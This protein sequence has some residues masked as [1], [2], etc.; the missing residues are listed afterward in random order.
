[1]IKERNYNGWNAAVLSNGNLEVIAPLD[2]GPRLLSLRHGES[3]N[4]FYEFPEERGGKGETHF[5]LRGGHRLWHSPEHPERTYQPD[6]DP[7]EF[8]TVGGGN[9][10][11]LTGRTEERTGLRKSI[12]VTLLGDRS[13]RVSHRLTHVGLW[14]VECAVWPLTMLRRGGT[15]ALPFPRKGE[16]P[17]DLL[18]DYGVVPWAYTDLSAACWRFHRDF[19][20]IDTREATAPQKLGL[21]R[22]PGWS[23]YWIEGRTFVKCAPVWAGA[24]YPDHGCCVEVFCNEAMIELETLSPLSRLEP[25]ASVEHEELWGLL[26]DLPRP[27]SQEVCRERFLPAVREWLEEVGARPSP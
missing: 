15:A 19:L 4:L 11:R 16:H 3:E 7:V 27:D 9:G 14:A 5:C 2:V 13:L 21:T 20:E 8:E 25:E 6:N 12:E 17:R 26:P 23:A 10:F 1:M 18:P 24:T 22:Y